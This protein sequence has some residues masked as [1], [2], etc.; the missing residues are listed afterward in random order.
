MALLRDGARELG[1]A[2]P[3]QD[4]LN[5]HPV[6][7]VP[8]WLAMVSLPNF[9]WT[10]QL[11]FASKSAMARTVTRFQYRLM[12][13]AYA[14]P[15]SSRLRRWTSYACQAVL[16][17]PGAAAGLG[18]LAYRRLTGTPHP[19]P[20]QRLLDKFWAQRKKPQGSVADR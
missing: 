9:V 13:L 10:M 2:R 8:E 19:L 12:Y 6:Q 5:A 7:A 16:L 17:L 15:T 3:Y 18:V 20:A 11:F 4:F 1:L 14:C